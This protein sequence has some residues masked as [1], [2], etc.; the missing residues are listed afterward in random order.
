MIAFFSDCAG[1]FTGIFNACM[2][3]SFFKAIAGLLLFWMTVGMFRLF[4]GL[5]RRRV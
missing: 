5:H 3:I 2:A 1:L 4:S